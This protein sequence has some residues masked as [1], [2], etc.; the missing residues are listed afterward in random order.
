MENSEN[1]NQMQQPSYQTVGS[2]EKKKNVYGLTGFILAIVGLVVSWVPVL[3]WIVWL[4]GLIFSCIG[5][6]RMP[7]GFAIAGLCISCLGLILLIV[8]IGA[9]SS[10][11]LFL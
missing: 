5:M 7:R 1:A 4:L 2:Q 6:F 8:L 10:V 3:G 9:L 11:F